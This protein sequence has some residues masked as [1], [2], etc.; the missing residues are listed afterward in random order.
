MARRVAG[1]DPPHSGPEPELRIGLFGHVAVEVNGTPFRLATPRKTLPVLA[2]LLLNR[3]AP[4]ARD[5]LAYVMWPDEEEEP[6]R[7]KLRMTLY[8]L[9]RVLP[10]E[11]E[12]RAL[13]VDGDSVCLRPDLNLW[14]DVEEF[15]RLIGNP[16]RTEDAVGLY[17]GDLLAALYDEWVFP[18]R[19]RHRNAFLAGLLQLVSQARRQRN[20]ISGIAR[21]QQILAIDPWRE[22][23]VRQ[24][25][26]LRCES[27]DR[28]GALA[29]YE[30]F[31][32]L[33]RLE[34]NV[35]PMPETLTLRETIARG[36]VSE[37]NAPLEPVATPPS[38][39]R[40]TT[41]PFVGRQME[42]GQ[43]LETWS[44]AVR[45]RGACVFLAESP[46][47]ANLVW[48]SSSRTRSKRAVGESSSVPPARRR[49]LHTRASSMRC[50]RHCRWSRR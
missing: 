39:A 26:A 10:P 45:G 35:Q 46:A 8:D 3:D 33:L 42:M 4:I 36:D 20:F 6:A 11:L 30:R 9:A 27:G 2:Y 5:F 37:P 40:S 17:R 23:V 41:L 12:G 47:S 18:E 38:L 24:V 50:V 16:Q 34:L 43:L 49:Q 32:K 19:E 29:E 1:R 15:N 22:D 25:M 28:A 14:L 7:T 31:A 48:F 44:R 13:I 21:A